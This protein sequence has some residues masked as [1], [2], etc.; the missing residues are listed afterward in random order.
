MAKSIQAQAAAQIR[1]KMKEAGFKA[2]VSSF[3]ASMCNGVRVYCKEADMPQ[4]ERIKEICMPY[5]YG[6][7]NG[8]EDIYEYSNMSD[9]IPQVKFVSI[10]WHS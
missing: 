10:S 3:A 2:K 9:H 6:H 7:F 1:A 5:Q 8:M 4:A